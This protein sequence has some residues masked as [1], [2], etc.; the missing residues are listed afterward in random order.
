VRNKRVRVR[1]RPT[2]KGMPMREFDFLIN[3]LNVHYRELGRRDSARV[4]PWVRIVGLAMVYKDPEDFPDLS[5]TKSF[6]LLLD[7]ADRLVPPRRYTVTLMRRGL[8]VR[9]SDE[10]ATKMRLVAWRSLLALGL[11]GKW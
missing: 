2:E 8:G 6:E 7:A 4:L 5:G 10:E 1:I 3:P 9:K 11:R